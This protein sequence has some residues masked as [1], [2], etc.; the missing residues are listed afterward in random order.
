MLHV[1]R[2]LVLH[3]RLLPV[4][5]DLGEQRRHVRFGPEVVER[6]EERLEVEDDGAGEG[7][8]AEGLPVDAQVD[9]GDGEVGHL[10]GAEV[11]VGVAGRHEEGGVDLETPGAALDG[12]VG[13]EVGEVAGVVARSVGQRVG[14]DVKEGTY[15]SIENSIL[16]L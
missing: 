12:A 4:P 14:E 9:A 3:E 11:F 10:A 5:E 7:E 8:A 15:R 1:P 2:A 16:A 6:G 13:G